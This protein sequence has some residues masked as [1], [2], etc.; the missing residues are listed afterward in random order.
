MSVAVGQI[1][2]YLKIGAVGV[3]IMLPIW[4]LIRF[5]EK[6]GREKSGR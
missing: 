3:A 4:L 1:I 6:K 5:I 2:A